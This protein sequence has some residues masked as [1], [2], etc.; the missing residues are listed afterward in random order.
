MAEPTSPRRPSPQGLDKTL[1][2]RMI[3]RAGDP[4]TIRQ[5]A[6][7][8]AAA[9]CGPLAERLGK[10]VGTEIGVDQPEVE[11]GLHSALARKLDAGDLRCRAGIKDW[12]G[13]L[14]LCTTAGMAIAFADRMLGGDGDGAVDRPLSPIEQDVSVVFFEQFLDALKTTVGK[15]DSEA[16]TGRPAAGAAMEDE[17]A[18]NH[19]VMVVL[20]IAFG[21][22]HG[23]I[24]L[25]LPQETVLKT[26]IVLPEEPAAAEPDVPREW[27]ERLNRQVSR[28]DVKLTGH[29]RLAPLT[30]G[31]L[32]RLEP[33]DVLPFADE[34]DVSVRLEAN[35]RELGWCDLG[36]SGN[37]YMLRLKPAGS[38]EAE[39]AH[40]LS[41]ST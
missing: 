13:D 15:A 36:R 20:Q 8:L 34:G 4:R 28:S 39:I 18:D 6:A 10:V 29:I 41:R 25:L 19:F 31:D 23:P 21:E 33:G 17:E 7:T 2:A 40:D 38:L 9:L 32:A 26:E 14:E 11:L 24:R 27:R 35:G 12:C 1:L 5:K 37:R 22:T 3:G 16:S 30:L